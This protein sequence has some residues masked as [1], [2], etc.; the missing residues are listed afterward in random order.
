[1]LMHHDSTRSYEEAAAA[2][3]VTARA[4]LEALI[5]HGAGRAAAVVNQ[6]MTQQPTD[7]LVR[8]PAVTFSP[9]DGAHLTA[10]FNS[11]NDRDRPIHRHALQQLAG[12]LG[13]PWSYLETLL[14]ASH[15]GGWGAELAARNLNELLRNAVDPTTRYLVRSVKGEARGWLSDRFRR[16]DCRPIVEAFALAC[17]RIGAVPCE[18]HALETKI[19]IKAM[20]PTVYEPV[21]H[22]V[23]TFGVVLENSD[24]GNGALTLRSFMLRLFCTNT[25]ICDHNVREVHLGAKLAEDIEW[26]DET[27]QLDTRRMAAMVGDVVR[28]QL[29]PAKIDTL[30][31]AIVKA[32]DEQVNPEKMLATLGKS[33]TKGEVGQVV[34]KFNSPDVELLPPGNTQWRMSNAVSWRAGQLPDEERRLELEKV[35]GQLATR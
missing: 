34:T 28:G 4:K 5:A 25:A 2:A 27:Y 21:K 31:A 12:R 23:M 19:A 9:A 22:E 10:R 17:Q 29:G 16:L 7:E 33:L 26:S 18:G 3:A 1:M 6:V 8:A 30:M 13:V 11:D 35:A 15:E 14:D 24:F 32:N 20:L